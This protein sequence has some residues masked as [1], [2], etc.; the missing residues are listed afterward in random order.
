MY[1]ALLLLCLAGC[2]SA[3][4]APRADDT[5]AAEDL[6]V[7]RFDAMGPAQ[8]R[9]LLDATTAAH[10][11]WLQSRPHSYALR[12]VEVGPCFEIHTIEAQPPRRPVYL[13]VGD[14]IVG[15]RPGV[16]ADSLDHACWRRWTAD[17][18]FAQVFR[19]LENPGRVLDSVV[20]DPRY[21][22]PRSYVLDRGGHGPSHIVVDRFTVVPDSAPQPDSGVSDR[23]AVPQPRHTQ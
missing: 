21:G 19:T 13:I 4:N 1:R 22:I 23:P 3:R 7:V 15:Q 11:R 8:R 14:S 17:S 18:I 9:Q 5:L 20:F 2:A 12:V 10:A 16:I 6:G